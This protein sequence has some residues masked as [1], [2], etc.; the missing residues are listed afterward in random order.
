MDFALSSVKEVAI[1]GELEDVH[2]KALIQQLWGTYRPHLVA[3][4]SSL[5]PDKN[6]PE[7]LKE[8]ELYI[9]KPTAYVCERFVC[10][11]PVNSPSELEMLL[12]DE[13]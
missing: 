10:L 9:S 4:I 3:A 11:R 12:S 2:T 8:R 6:A 7:L 5:P 1:I 13:N